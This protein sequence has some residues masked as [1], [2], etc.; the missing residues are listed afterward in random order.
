VKKLKNITILLI[1][2]GICYYILNDNILLI[3]FAQSN[4]EKIITIPKGSANPEVDITKFTSK[5]WYNPS[6]ITINV[7]DTIKWINNDTESHTV[8]SGLGGG[9]ASAATNSKGKPN[10]LFDSGLFKPD[11]S[12][13]LKFNKSGTFN[14]FCTI[15]PWMEGIV[16]VN[17]ASVNTKIPTYAV[18]QYGNKIGKFPLYNLTSDKKIEIGISWNP[19]S[20]KTNEPISFIIDAFKMPE[21]TVLH[22]WSY[23]FILIQNGKE[24]Y[25]TNG[26]TEMGSS[27]EKYTFNSPGNLSIK[28]ESSQ[29]PRSVMEYNTIVYKNPN[30]SS[31]SATS[32]NNMQNMPKSSS[33]SGLINSLTLVY[34]VYAIIIGLPIALVIIVILI[35]KRII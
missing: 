6:P 8:T 21:N 25:R 1:L 18:N 2:F 32:N 33:S 20:I 15:H 35:K 30:S 13:S 16:N 31:S 7:N 17:D 26:H 28:I 24:I 4:G 10:G 3:S 34:S 12:Y 11:S 19:M 5:Q 14:Y 22:L 9:M 23:N 27:A 29:D